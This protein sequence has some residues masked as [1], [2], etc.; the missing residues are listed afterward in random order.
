MSLRRL[1][2]LGLL[3]GTLS[4]MMGSG[5]KQRPTEVVMPKLS[6][7]LLDEVH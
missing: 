1:T 3:F 5:C 7:Q 2:L 4:L 6:P